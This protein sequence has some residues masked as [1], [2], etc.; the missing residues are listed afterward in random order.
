MK[1]DEARLKIVKDTVVNSI[2]SEMYEKLKNKISDEEKRKE[3][4]SLTRSNLDS[5]LK[6]FGEKE[7]LPKKD[8]SSQQDF[9]EHI[10]KIVQKVRQK[11]L[12]EMEKEN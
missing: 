4:I 9:E 5:I 7:L 3:M 10:L 12:V 11:L 2:L 8:F 1:E 6:S